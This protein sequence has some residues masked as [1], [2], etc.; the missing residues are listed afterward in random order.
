M[1][2]NDVE[3]RAISL[4][5]FDITAAL[6]DQNSPE[7]MPLATLWTDN[8]SDTDLWIREETRDA[9]SQ[10]GEVKIAWTGEWQLK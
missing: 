3:T 2:Y 9:A 4:G 6:Q 5:W 1:F 8:L 7:K 10:W